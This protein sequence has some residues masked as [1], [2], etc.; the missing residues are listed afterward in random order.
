MKQT[1]T[2]I[3]SLVVFCVLVL[4]VLAEP[5]DDV[6]YLHDCGWLIFLNR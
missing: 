2:G 1:G 4:A 5:R 3:F 6:L